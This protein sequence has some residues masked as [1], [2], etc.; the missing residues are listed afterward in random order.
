MASEDANAYRM[1]PAEMLSTY[2]V[3]VA[4]AGEDVVVEMTAGAGAPAAPGRSGGDVTYLR[5]VGYAPGLPT[6]HP[7]AA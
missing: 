7:H 3:R 2:S 4:C 1:D 6:A 5:G